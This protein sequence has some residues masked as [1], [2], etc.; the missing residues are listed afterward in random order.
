MNGLRLEAI[1]GEKLTE[2]L[3]MATEISLYALIFTLPISKSMVEIFFGCAL[4]FWAIKRFITWYRNGAPFLKVFRPVRTRLDRPIAIFVFIGFLSTLTSVSFLLSLDGF[5]FKLAE[6]IMTYFMVVEVLSDR[7]KV[8]RML[9]AMLLIMP[10]VIIDGFYQFATGV[11]FIRHYPPCNGRMQASFHSPNDFAG[12]LVVMTPLALSL[13]CFRGG[14]WPD[15]SGRSGWLK[16]MV[17]P[18]LCTL[19]VLLTVCLILTYS[20]GA[21]IAFL[22]SIVFLGVLCYRKLLL[23]LA[24]VMAAL[25]FIVSH[26][27]KER[28]VSLMELAD[29]GV[30]VRLQVWKGVLNIIRDFPLTGCGL[31]TYTIVAPKYKIFEGFFECYPHN[32]YLHMAVESGILGLAAF[33]WVMFALFKGVL[34]ARK[35]ISDGFLRALLMGLLAGLLGFLVHSCFDT[36]FYALKLGVLMWFVIGLIVA[37]QRTALRES[38]GN[39]Q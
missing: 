31:N 32:A 13:A 24:P 4:T 27:I 5:F 36:N 8:G 23:I 34:A 25:P 33:I 2:W 37:V 20:R 19:T 21:W 15:F 10:L 30:L 35:K 39:S 38:R 7:K 17:R 26:S 14:N 29:T 16:K 22:V 9:K 18:A 11:D 12:W 3:N 6:L 1:T 28:A